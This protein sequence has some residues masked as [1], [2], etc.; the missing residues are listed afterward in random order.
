MK[1]RPSNFC[2]AGLV[3]KVMLTERGPTFTPQ[4]MKGVQKAGL[5]FEKMVHL[6]MKMRFGEQYH[7]NPW[8]H[9]YSEGAW[10]WCQPDGILCQPDAGLITI[11]ECKLKHTAR[12]WFQL[13]ERYL[14]VVKAAFGDSFVY[15]LVEVCKFYDPSTPYPVKA[16]LLRELLV[17]PEPESVGVFL[18]NK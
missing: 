7:S 12:S 5:V 8:F 15:N 16:P 11:F 17:S 3:Q 6:N 9:F 14:P 13:T 18:W 1:L 4:K 10:H 2:P